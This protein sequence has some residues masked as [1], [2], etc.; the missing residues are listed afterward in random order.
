MAIKASTSSFRPFGLV[1]R[2]PLL[3]PPLS[4]FFVIPIPSYPLLQLP[5]KCRV[6]IVNFFAIFRRMFLVIGFPASTFWRL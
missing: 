6:G 3:L 2:L 5:R 1:S 4:T